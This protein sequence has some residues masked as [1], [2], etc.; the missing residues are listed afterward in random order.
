MSLIARLKDILKREGLYVEE[1]FEE[2]VSL[3]KSTHQ[4]LDRVLTTSGYLTE[5]QMLEIFGECLSL[6]V[7]DHLVDSEVPPAFVERVPVQFARHHNLVAIGG[8]NGTVRVAS[9]SPL[10][11]H[12]LDDLSAML[13]T[14]VEPVLAP[15]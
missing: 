3:A 4:T 11:T 15:R 8:F 14:I 13:D 5:K 9:C 2:W 6:P 12:P 7:I 10:D 1:K